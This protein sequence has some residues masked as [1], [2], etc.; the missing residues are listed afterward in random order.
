MD[1]WRYHT[2]NGDINDANVE[3]PKYMVQHKNIKWLVTD[4]V[5]L[6]A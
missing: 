3:H 1:N 2:R 5:A 6:A 4:I